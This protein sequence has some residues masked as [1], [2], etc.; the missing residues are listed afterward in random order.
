MSTL[1]VIAKS[2]SYI[3]LYITA[4]NVLC[5]I[6][7]IGVACLRLGQGKIFIFFSPTDNIILLLYIPLQLFCEQHVPEMDMCQI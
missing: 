4:Y 6:W 1:G 3:S 2:A 5:L 7:Q